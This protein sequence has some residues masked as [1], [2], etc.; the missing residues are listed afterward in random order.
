LWSDT[1]GPATLPEGAHDQFIVASTNGIGMYTTKTFGVGSHGCSLTGAATMWVC[2]SDRDAKENFI[3]LDAPDVL[4]RV[5]TMSITRWN[6]KGVPGIEHIGP[7]AQDFHAAFGLGADDLH[8]G[9]GDL[10]GVALVAIQGLHQELMKRDALIAKQG[11]EIAELRHMLLEMR[12]AME[13][14]AVM[15]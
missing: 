6:E 10:S 8:I 7:V 11:N 12:N 3:Q 1:T 5:S 15:H 14:K 13:I 9:S 4:R 2:T